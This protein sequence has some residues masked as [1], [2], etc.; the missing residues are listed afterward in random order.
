MS[1]VMRTNTK[2]TCVSDRFE[3]KSNRIN[4]KL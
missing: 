4:E 3:F 2:H 1:K